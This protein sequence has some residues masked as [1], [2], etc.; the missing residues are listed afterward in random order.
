MRQDFFNAG[1][2][3]LKLADETWSKF[4]ESVKTFNANKNK[5]YK[6]IKK[7][8]SENLKRKLELIKVAEDNKNSDDFSTV[9]ALM[10]KI[11]SDWKKIGHVPR[12]DS[13]KV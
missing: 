11:Q 2:V 12:K 8:Q 6:S 7:E 5:F 3:P 4:K 9:T 13:D 10:K 1:K